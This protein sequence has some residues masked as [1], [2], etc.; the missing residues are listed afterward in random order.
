MPGKRR[1][2]TGAKAS[3]RQGVSKKR[4]S[5]EAGG[6]TAEEGVEG[7]AG[8]TAAVGG[9]D[10]P[11]REEEVEGETGRTTAVADQGAT[12]VVDRNFPPGAEEGE[13]EAGGTA[14]T[15]AKDALDLQKGNLLQDQPEGEKADGA[16]STCRP[17]I[18]AIPRR[19]RGAS[20][21]PVH[22]NKAQDKSEPDQDADRVQRSMS[23]R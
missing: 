11:Q 20:E 15:A 14:T 8:E 9:S 2:R 18:C 19:M 1:G 5:R 12:A 16:D 22:R 13:G 7:E 17:S 4:R 23:L 6:E 21:R 10:L 3:S